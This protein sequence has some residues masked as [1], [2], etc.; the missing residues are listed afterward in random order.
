MNQPKQWPRIL[1]TG[2]GGQL[3]RELKRSL[4]CLG[5]LIACD[6]RQL[7]LA[8][9]DALCNAVRTMAPTVIVNAAAYTA[10]DKAE[11]EPEAAQAINA[12]AP[13]ILAEEAKRLDA[14]LIH[15]STDYV[16]DGS[17]P[18]P[19]TENDAPAPL[20]AYPRRLRPGQSLEVAKECACRHFPATFH[21]TRNSSF[22]F[23]FATSSASQCGGRPRP[24]QVSPVDG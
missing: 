8:N 2:S 16:F 4:A 13:G 7:D 22:F 14:L 1:L 9:A 24:D 20:A 12:I 21:P 11:T 17:K 23:P 10:V 15:F 5:D 19:Y 18:S 6:H 3:G